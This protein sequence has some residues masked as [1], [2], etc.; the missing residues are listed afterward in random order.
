MIVLKRNQ[1]VIISLATLVAVAGYLNLSY[2]N[3]PVAPTSSEVM[4]E[5]KLVENGDGEN[6]FFAEARME[7]EDSRSKAVAVMQ[8]VIDTGEK[9]S[10][11]TAEQEKLRMAKTSESETTIENLIRAKG[12]EDAMVY[13]QDE[14][15]IAIVKTSQA[16]LT[17]ADAAKIVEIVTEQTGMPATA[18][19]IV[20]AE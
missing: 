15:V 19:N 13:I 5:V 16:E 9:T 7:R 14:K 10:K 2:K 18:V 8:E 12:F 3:E 1:V 20:E 4:G 17:G 11:E 6:D